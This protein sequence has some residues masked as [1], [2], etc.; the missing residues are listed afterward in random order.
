MTSLDTT[1]GAVVT[2]G[3]RRRSRRSPI[4]PLRPAGSTPADSVPSSSRADGPCA[5]RRISCSGSRN[6]R[7]ARASRS[8]AHQPCECVSPVVMQGVYD[9]DHGFCA[10]HGGCASRYVLPLYR[11]R[12]R[13]PSAFPAT[14]VFRLRV[15]SSGVGVGM[16]TRFKV[17]VGGRSREYR[18]TVTEPEPD[19]RFS[20]PS[21]GLHHLAGRAV[22]AR[23]MCSGVGRP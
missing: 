1:L 7:V 19:C 9:K 8:P 14:G 23:T 5:A 12:T 2:V 11:G 10:G 13:A 21:L 18:M 4:Q 22:R 17:T 6:R 15:E 16:I 3:K 20:I